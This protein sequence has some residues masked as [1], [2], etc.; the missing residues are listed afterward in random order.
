MHIATPPTKARPENTALDLDT[1]TATRDE[2]HAVSTLNDMPVSAKIYDNL[3]DAT[4][5]AH[6]VAKYGDVAPDD[7]NER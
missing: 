7:F 2:E 3:P 5:N 6:D 4:L 1:W